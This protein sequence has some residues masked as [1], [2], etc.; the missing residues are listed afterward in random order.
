MKTK[1]TSDANIALEIEQWH[2][3][4]FLGLKTRGL[5]RL[6]YKKNRPQT[7]LS[8]P[9]KRFSHCC[10]NFAASA[11]GKMKVAKRKND[12]CRWVCLLLSRKSRGKFARLLNYRF[13][14]QKY[15]YIFSGDRNEKKYFYG[16]R[17]SNLILFFLKVGAPRGQ[18]WVIVSA[19]LPLPPPF[20]QKKK[21][22]EMAI[23]SF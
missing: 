12:G 10:D 9:Q 4:H 11:E 23:S 5:R 15:K 1:T 2:T 17:L 3:D 8:F 20:A 21:V 16:S 7:S 22:R 19:S 18:K 6:P 14:P 13:S